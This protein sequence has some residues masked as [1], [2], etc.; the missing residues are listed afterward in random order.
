MKK[1]KDKRERLTARNK[2]IH[3]AFNK[4]SAKKTAS[5]KPIYTFE[6]I[7]EQLEDMFPPLSRAYIQQILS[8]EPDAFPFSRTQNPRK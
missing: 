5:G 7:L 8:N 1:P 2:K 4:L 3:A 6:F